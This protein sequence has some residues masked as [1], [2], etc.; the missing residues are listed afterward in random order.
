[1]I[2]ELADVRTGVAASGGDGLVMPAGVGRT[3]V[4]VREDEWQVADVDNLAVQ[5]GA[6]YGWA[7]LSNAVH[8]SDVVIMS[9]YR[10]GGLTHRY[11]SDQAMLVDWFIDDNG[12]TKFR[13][14]EVEYPEDAPSPSG[15]LGADPAVLAPFGTGRVDLE[16]LGACL[17]GHFADQ[18]HVFAE[19]QHKMIL[20]AL[21][22]DP[23][24]FDARVSPHRPR[25]CRT[26]RRPTHLWSH[27]K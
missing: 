10:D 14:G 26:A 22:L 24:R 13:I 21:N 9:A 23:S 27:L 11:V 5:L 20:E 6:A 17:R 2:A 4:M 18:E 19:Q 1:V 25:R 16:R 12:T 7:A 8:D 15:P 3:A